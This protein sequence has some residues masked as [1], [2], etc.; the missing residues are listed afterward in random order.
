MKLKL[1][2]KVLLS[3]LSLA[4]V[5]V[6]F[7]LTAKFPILAQIYQ[8]FAI[9]LLSI[10]GIHHASDFGS[11]FIGSYNPVQSSNLVYNDPK[12]NNQGQGSDL[13][14]PSL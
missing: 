13:P 12:T 10:T 5:T 3:F 14:P 4:L 8:P 9:A 6:G 11:S 7:I 1:T 2:N